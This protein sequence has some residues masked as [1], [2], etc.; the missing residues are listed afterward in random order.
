MSVCQPQNM[1]V[2]NRIYL[3]ST[4]IL[5]SVSA[6][7]AAAI[8]RA[9]FSSSGECGGQLENGPSNVQ[10]DLRPMMGAVTAL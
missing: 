4:R 7:T 10:H 5:R 2:L 1:Y 6:A 8:R 3:S 9:R